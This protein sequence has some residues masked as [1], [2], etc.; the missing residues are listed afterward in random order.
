M[1]SQQSGTAKDLSSIAS[2]Q[3]SEQVRAAASCIGV[4]H[5]CEV[6]ASASLTESVGGKIDALYRPIARR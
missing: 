5:S 2:G 3:T 4:Q 1:G 6:E